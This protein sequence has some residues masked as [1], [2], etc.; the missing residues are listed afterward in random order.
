MTEVR[1]IFLI[2]PR[3]DPVV[4]PAQLRLQVALS[5][6][7]GRL[8][9]VG[10]SY[11]NLALPD[12]RSQML[13]VSYDRTFR[14]GASLFVSGTFNLQDRGIQ[15]SAGFS[16]LLGEGARS[17][18]DTRSGPSGVN[19]VSTLS[20][21]SNGAF[22]WSVGNSV[23][24]NASQW[25]SVGYQASFADLGGR[26]AHSGDGLRATAHADGAIVIAG[27]G[28]FFG[29]PIGDAF[30][31]VDVGAPGVDVFSE[32]RL[33]GRTNTNGRL[34]ITNLRSYQ[35]NNIAIDPA[36]LPLDATFASTRMLVV[37]ADRSGV[38]ARFEV[39]TGASAAV[40]ILRDE[41]GI[42]LPVGSIATLERSAT[43]FIVGYDGMAYIDGLGPQNR[44]VVQSPGGVC[45]ADFAFSPQPGEQVQVP[46]TCVKG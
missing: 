19:V 18:V 46:V 2:G 9:S 15:A 17:A 33:V 38:V 40:I 42:V 25:A 3:L 12:E 26:I 7:L 21:S 27:G 28:I 34:L 14:N 36:N 43:A 37:P 23:G 13:G 6:P 11:T 39:T 41:Q 22:D 32:N 44:I 35:E 31:V 20:R 29:P 4:E 45:Q 1:S 5:L 24:P 16:V 10:I 30:A 8:G